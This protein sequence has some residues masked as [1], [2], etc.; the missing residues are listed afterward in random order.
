MHV[1]GS[2]RPIFYV[3]DGHRPVP[4]ADGRWLANAPLK[5]RLVE[6][7]DEGRATVTTVFLGQDVAPDGPP[8]VFE[9]LVRGGRLDGVRRTYSTYDEA[10]AGHQRVL[11]DLRRDLS[12]RARGRT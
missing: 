10:V 9:T 11:K 6:R 1:S 8:L 4:S 12:A 7:S 3:V 2:T 5:D